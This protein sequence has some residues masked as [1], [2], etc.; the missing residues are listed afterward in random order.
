LSNKR[1]I[2]VNRRT[3]T[4]QQF[5]SRFGPGALKQAELRPQVRLRPS[6]K[7]LIGQDGYRDRGTPKTL[8]F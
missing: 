5:D 7:M 6:L 8:A 3:S 1:S 4:F 2:E